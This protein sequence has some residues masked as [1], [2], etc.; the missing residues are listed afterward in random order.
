MNIEFRISDVEEKYSILKLHKLEINKEIYEKMV[1]LN[2]MWHSLLK[3]VKLVNRQLHEK[4]IVFADQTK[5]E[6]KKLREKI[7][8]E[9]QKYF[10]K[11]PGA[12][13]TNLKDGYRLLEETFRTLKDL[14]I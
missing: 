6:V 2:R 14:N 11:G 4:K 7:A 9:H 13:D 1:S 5:E 8:Q 3:R 12:T 10:E